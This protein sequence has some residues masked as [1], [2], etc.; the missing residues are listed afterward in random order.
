M[1]FEWD[2]VKE[3]ANH[4][5]HKVPFSEASETFFDPKGL[6]FV[7]SGHSQNENRYYFIG[8]TYEGRILTTWFTIRE[9]TIRIIGSAE[10]QKFR[11]PCN[12]TAEN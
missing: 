6:K 8:K 1:E 4:L 10:F 9:E 12:E 5:K 3:K 2:Y 11:R 7:D